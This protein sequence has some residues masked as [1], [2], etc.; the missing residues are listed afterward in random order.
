[1]SGIA[2]AAL[3]IPG[4]VAPLAICS[5]EASLLIDSMRR[6]SA[7]TRPGTR[8]PRP[9]SRGIR[10]RYG[11]TRSSCILPLSGSAGNRRGGTAVRPRHPDER[12]EHTHDARELGNAERAEPEA[13]EAERLDR[14][15]A[16]RVETDVGKEQG[17]RTPS[18][19]RA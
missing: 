1:M 2:I 5:S 7:T 3:T 16:D 19:P 9:A 4:S 8:M 10:Q 18:E 6:A 15:A 12:D 11:P 17:A 14:E 13:V